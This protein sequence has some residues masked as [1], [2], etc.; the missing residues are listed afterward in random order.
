MGKKRDYRRTILVVD[1][2]E[3][4]RRILGMI[5]EPEYEV[6]YAE[7]GVTAM[8]QIRAHASMLSLILLDL[9]MPE[10]DGFEVLESLRNDPV[11]SGIPVIVLTSDHSAEIKSL[12]LGAADFL[13]KPYDLPEVILAR[14]SHSIALSENS[15]I[16]QAT[17]NDALTDLYTREFFFEYGHQY[18]HHHS[19]LAMDAIVLNFNR[20]HLVNE[21]Y[22]RAFGDRVLKK[23]GGGIREIIEEAGGIACRYDA[24]TFYIYLSHQ[25]DYEGLLKRIQQGLSEL[26]QAPE[27]RLRMGIYPDTYRSVTL[28]QRFE[29]ALQACNS[30]RA[31]FGAAFA[32]YDMEMHEREVYS[33]RLLEDFEEALK[34]KQFRVLYQPKY[35]IRG[36]KPRLCSAEALIT[37]QHPE[38][39]RVRPDAFI[40]LFEENG[41]IQKLDRYVW[42]EAT[43]QIKNWKESFGVTVPISVNVS[44][45][46]IYDPD[47]AE[48]IMELVEE[49]DIAVQEYLLEI[50]ESAYTDNSRQIVQVVKE[51]RAAGFQVEMDDFGSGYSSLNMLT[52]LPLDALKLD[53]AFIHNIS[54]DNKEM[55]MVELVLEI[56]E[57]LGVPVIAEGVETVDQYELLKNA[58]CDIIQGYY[59]SR[60]IPPEEF[61]RLIRQE[62]EGQERI[63]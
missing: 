21:L 11:L 27:V 1:D 50:T 56:A 13:E 32:I 55:R 62:T 46:D 26:L 31:Q 49:N 7:N 57:F 28:E 54:V 29:R 63:R 47:M 6:I 16:I 8:Q 42:K 40:P 58:G 44:R 59:F 18:D 60:P 43:L 22:G 48:Y 38:F 41:L 4:N 2:E 45:V 17:E 51:L 24:D 37:W 14:I 9:M 36:S 35:D 30:L 25:Q 3:V 12:E 61:G 10:M 15:R 52:A 33:A 5:A 34:N 19:D 39:G 20:F 23:I 53:M